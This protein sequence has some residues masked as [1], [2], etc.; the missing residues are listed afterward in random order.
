MLK[1]CARPIRVEV[2]DRCHLEALRQRAK[3]LDVRG[4][5]PGTDHSYLS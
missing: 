4:A 2:A 5:N 1:A 3:A